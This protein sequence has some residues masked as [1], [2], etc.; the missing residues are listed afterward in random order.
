M[1]LKTPGLAAASAASSPSDVAAVPSLCNSDDYI[2]Q[3]LREKSFDPKGKATSSVLDDLVSTATAAPAP[4]GSTCLTCCSRVLT[5]SLRS[6]HQRRPLVVGR[7]R[8]DGRRRRVS[9]L[10][11]VKRV[12]ST[13]SSRCPSVPAEQQD[14]PSTRIA[15]NARP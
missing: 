9:C 8:R 5:G 11:S 13:S 4:P 15:R 14:A 3:K 1:D 6:R 7:G 10:V 2:G 12:C